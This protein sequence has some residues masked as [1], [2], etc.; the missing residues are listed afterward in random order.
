MQR[1]SFRT[2]WRK[3]EIRNDFLV[4]LGASNQ[5]D[6]HSDK[7]PQPFAIINSAPSKDR[8]E[9]WIITVQLDEIY[10]FD[11]SSSLKRTAY[12][13]LKNYWRMVPRKL[14]KN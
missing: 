4:S 10:Y 5:S 3:L 2:Q 8:G 6:S 1:N 9:N 14:Q 13:L 12:S 11:V 7:L